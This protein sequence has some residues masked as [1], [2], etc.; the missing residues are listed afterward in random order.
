ME[1]KNGRAIGFSVRRNISTPS[2]RPGSQQASNT[3][4]IINVHGSVTRWLHYLFNIWPYAAMKLAQK[5]NK[6]ASVCSKFCQI[7]NRPYNK[8]P[9][10]FKISPKWRNFAKSGHTDAW[11]KP[12]WFDLP[13]V[14]ASASAY[15]ATC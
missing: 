4:G 15:S 5:H 6:F 12:Y 14:A 2:G 10:S 3:C 7:Q 11:A 9:K 1:V 13:V 8:L